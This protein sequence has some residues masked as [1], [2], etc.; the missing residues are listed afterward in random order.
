[1]DCALKKLLIRKKNR[2]SRAHGT[3]SVT[4]HTALGRSIFFEISLFDI[5]S[6]RFFLVPLHTVFN[7][8]VIPSAGFRCCLRGANANNGGQCGLSTLNVN[9][10]VDVSNVNY[11]AALN[12]K[13]LLGCLL[14][15]GDSG[16]RPCPMAKNTHEEI[17]W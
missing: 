1:M 3:R 10:A 11:G 16:V 7:Q 17:S 15:G 9:N 8:V 4:L 14:P 12:F 13:T 6:Y 5:F 2:G